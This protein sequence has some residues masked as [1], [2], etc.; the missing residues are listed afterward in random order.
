M[1]SPLAE[2]FRADLRCSDSQADSLAALARERM[3]SIVGSAEDSEEDLV[4]RL[5]DPRAFGAFVGSVV[6][7]PRLPP[8]LQTSLLEQVFDLLSVPRTEGEVMAVEARAPR[9][10]VDLAARLGAKEGLSILHVMHLVYAVFLD[11]SLLTDAPRDRRS[12]VFRTVA[13][14]TE[15]GEGLRV[16]YAAFH[17]ASIPEAEAARELRWFLRASAIPVGVRRSIADM[18]TADDG[19]QASL[20]RLAQR[21]GLLPA[22]L[23]EVR[24]PLITANIPKLPERLAAAGRRY[25]KRQGD[26]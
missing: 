25:T 6:E 13:T 20:T 9:N 24:G 15:S 26:A 4:L 18:A 22:D 21:E 11:R 17:L 8:G 23:G 3:P 5:R 7:D 12:A 1:S 19:G 16:L 10:L 14:G 2:A